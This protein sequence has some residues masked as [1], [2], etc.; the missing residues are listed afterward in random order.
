MPLTTRCRHCG[1]LFP[2]YAQQL[3]ERH[4]KVECPQCGN[5]FD[6]L[7][8]LIDEAI[9]GAEVGNA[10]KAATTRR[11]DSTASLAPLM[12]FGELQDRPA[13][14]TGIFWT[15]GV[16]MLLAGLAAQA[17]WWERGTWLRYPLVRQL[18]SQAC[19][20]YDVCPP[21]PRLAGTMEILQPV[22]SEHPLD[23]QVLRLDFTIVNHAEQIQ[24]LPILQL[25][26]YDGDGEIMAAGRFTPD[27]YMKIP[28]RIPAL[29][30]GR[31]MNVAMEI[32]TPSTT[33]TSFRIRLY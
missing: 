30:S 7:D 27:Q 17:F 12:T 24:R 9:P 11:Q 18:Y 4:G 14:A 1:R 25:E 19:T 10:K 16:L 28:Q 29:P 21:L 23:D 33:P 15:L 26:L 6:G 22:L 3:K 13:R 8:G 5:R 2:V 31:A 32:A 20:D